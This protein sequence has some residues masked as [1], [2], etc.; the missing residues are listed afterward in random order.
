M[1]KLVITTTPSK[2]ILTVYDHKDKLEEIVLQEDMFKL[3]Q[4]SI[5]E[6]MKAHKIARRHVIEI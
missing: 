4:Q 6:L 3:K 2:I 5:I 1:N